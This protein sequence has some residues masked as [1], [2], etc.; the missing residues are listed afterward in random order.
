[1]C[2]YKNKLKSTKKK[3]TE[4]QG[5]KNWTY[6]REWWRM[7]FQSLLGPIQV[8]G[9]PL[10]KAQGLQGCCPPQKNQALKTVVQIESRTWDCHS[11]KPVYSLHW[12]Q[13]FHLSLHKDTCTHTHTHTHTAITINP[14]RWPTG[15]K[16]FLYTWSG[17]GTHLL[18]FADKLSKQCFQ[19][20]TTSS[21][22]L[23]TSKG[24]MAWFPARSWS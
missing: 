14:A 6:S 22:M 7:T 12:T 1:M 17:I 3:Q 8:L 24:F 9:W 5:K 4:K 20:P 11:K 10:S 13:I 15:R 2:K 16:L 18:S 23:A 21:M 19:S